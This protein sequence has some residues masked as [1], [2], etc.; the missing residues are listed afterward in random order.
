[1]KEPIKILEFNHCKIKDRQENG[2]R[3]FGRMLTRLVWLVYIFYVLIADV[4]LGREPAWYVFTGNGYL[5]F[6]FFLV[7][8]CFVKS[9]EEISVPIEIR[10]YEKYLTI[11]ESQYFDLYTEPC[12]RCFEFSYVDLDFLWMPEKDKLTIS[13]DGQK[14]IYEYT[15]DETL[16]GKPI[17]A[18]KNEFTVD[19]D[20]RYC[21]EIDFEEELERYVEALTTAKKR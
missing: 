7:S 4:I 9:V 8:L 17:K 16:L 18:E 12:K 5:F 10:F 1:M 21:R 14:Y 3:S 11:F 20:T 6:A 13:G 19:F 15:E 2:R